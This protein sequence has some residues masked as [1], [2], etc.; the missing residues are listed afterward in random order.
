M[1]RILTRR[2]LEDVKALLSTF[3]DQRPPDPTLLNDAG[4]TCDDCDL[5]HHV[6]THD[7]VRHLVEVSRG[8]LASLPKPAL[9]TIARSSR[10]DYCPPEDV[11]FIQAEILKMLEEIYGELDV[12]QDYDMDASEEEVP[13]LV[14]RVCSSEEE[15]PTLVDPESMNPQIHPQKPE[16]SSGLENQRTPEILDAPEDSGDSLAK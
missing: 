15:V 10:D 13:P 1:E 7:Q 12:H 14:R 9:V 8:F 16:S 11:D 4:C 5:P 6:S 2:R 3:P